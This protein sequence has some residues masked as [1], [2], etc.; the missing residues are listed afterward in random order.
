[1]R[2]EDFWIFEFSVTSSFEVIKDGL[3]VIDRHLWTNRLYKDGLVMGQNN[4]YCI[5]AIDL[6]VRR[7]LQYYLLL[8]KG[9]R[10]QHHYAHV[11][12]LKV[13]CG[14]LNLKDLPAH[15]I[16]STSS[17]KQHSCV[18]C[19]LDCFLHSDAWHAKLFLA[20]ISV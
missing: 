9:R 13:N 15:G 3:M 20:F 18:V 4:L 17:N 11:E 19:K 8:M 16:K 7:W 14:A 6:G 5:N 1:M 2:L 10:K 12:F